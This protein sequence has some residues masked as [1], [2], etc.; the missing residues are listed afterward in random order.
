VSRG[1][2]VGIGPFSDRGNMG[3]FRTREAAEEFIQ[4]DPFN[5]ERLLRSQRLGD[6][7]GTFEETR[8]EVPGDLVHYINYLVYGLFVSAGKRR[9]RGRSVPSSSSISLANPLSACS[10]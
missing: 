3:I 7:S 4:R 6:L 9:S 8:L 2:V 5:L 1:V 10:W